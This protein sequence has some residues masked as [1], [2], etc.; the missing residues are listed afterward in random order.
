MLRVRYMFAGIFHIVLPYR[1][2]ILY[3]PLEISCSYTGIQNIKIFIQSHT[4]RNIQHN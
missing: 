3:V 2:V 1:H 4:I